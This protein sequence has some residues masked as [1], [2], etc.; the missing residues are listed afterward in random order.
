[1]A[2]ASQ[3]LTWSNQSTAVTV[4]G[5]AD[6]PACVIANDTNVAIYARNDGVAAVVGAAGTIVIEPGAEWTL[7]NTLPLQN[8]NQNGSAAVYVCGVEKSF[9]QSE[10][11]N[12]TAQS[13]LVTD[14]LSLIPAS[15]TN[16]GTVTITFQ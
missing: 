15:G 8:A 3:T 11:V 13:G 2:D 9:S 12:W 1:M 6:A 5:T 4:T 14:S 10:N 16:A 7:D